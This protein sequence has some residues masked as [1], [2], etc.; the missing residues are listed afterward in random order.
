M[1]YFGVDQDIRIQE[2]NLNFKNQIRNRGGIGL[3]SLGKIF[4][5][6][7]ANLNRRLEPEEFEAALASCG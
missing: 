3:I 6:M 7:D 1:A 2:I 4:R 5:E